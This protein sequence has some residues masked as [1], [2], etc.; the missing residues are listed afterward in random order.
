MVDST[1]SSRGS[2]AQRIADGALGLADAVER[3]GID[4]AHAGIPGGADNG[5]GL[6]A[7]NR[8][9]GAAKRRT[10]ETESGDIERGASDPARGECRLWHLSTPGETRLGAPNPTV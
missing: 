9:T 3:R 7:G 6:G 1:H 10:A 8:N 5:L 4:I 2:V